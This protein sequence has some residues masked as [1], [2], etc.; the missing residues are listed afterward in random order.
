MSVIL[1]VIIFWLYS[2]KIITVSEL[3]IIEIVLLGLLLFELTRINKKIK[4]KL[5]D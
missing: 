3:I 5:Q 4:N 2:L 1:I